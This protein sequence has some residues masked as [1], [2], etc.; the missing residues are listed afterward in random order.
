[1]TFILVSRQL[2]TSF[3]HWVSCTTPG[4]NI[5]SF[6]GM[7]PWQQ[8]RI[9][10]LHSR[11][12]ASLW[13]FSR[14]ICYWLSCGIGLVMNIWAKSCHLAKLTTDRPGA[15]LPLT[16][17]LIRLPRDLLQSYQFCDDQKGWEGWPCRSR[18]RICVC[19][20][21]PWGARGLPRSERQEDWEA[22]EWNGCC[23]RS[24]PFKTS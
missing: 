15:V 24:D 8:T 9:P 14:M 16:D 11:W 6:P 19:P 10:V 21:D 1:M 4:K 5:W 7:Y 12:W 18:G 20:T 17:S 22:V 13:P 23:W 3:D 2:R